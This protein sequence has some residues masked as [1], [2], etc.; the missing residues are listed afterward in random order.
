MT[1][2]SFRNTTLGTI[3]A[4]LLLGVAT[5][6]LWTVLL[7][8]R[9]A[10]SIVNDSLRGLTAS[11]LAA[12]NIADGFLEMAIVITTSDPAVREK[13]LVEILRITAVT[14]GLLK[15]Y[16]SSIDEVQEREIFERLRE[17]RAEFR[18][19]RQRT[20]NLLHEGKRDEAVLLYN[21]TGLA[22]FFAYKEAA[23]LLVRYKVEEARTRGGQIL[24]LCKVLLILQGVLLVFF[25]V[26]AF[27]VPL[28][29]FFEKFSASG[30][31]ELVKD[32]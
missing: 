4:V 20:I 31:A 7:V 18:Q 10:V 28:V 2:T 25:F 5:S 19:T 8:K 6:P 16:E 30:D 3:A 13:N 17:K 24:Q 29:T 22:Q 11:S 26:Y 9:Q 27:F 15:S 1:T 23:D 32:L 12:I 14:D 21:Q